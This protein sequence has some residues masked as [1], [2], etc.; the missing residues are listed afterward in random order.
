MLAEPKARLL[1]PPSDLM[2][3][4]KAALLVGASVPSLEPTSVKSALSLEPP[5]A[6]SV[7]WLER[8]L[9]QLGSGSTDL[10]V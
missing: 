4:L 5:S 9:V 7:P 2:A 10:V 3:L 6:M 1:E 8:Q